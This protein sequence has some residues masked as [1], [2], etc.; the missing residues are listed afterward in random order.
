MGGRGGEVREREGEGKECE[1]GRERG[2]EGKRV[3]KGSREGG[4]DEDRVVGGGWG[5]GEDPPDRGREG[6]RR[7]A[8]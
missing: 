2:M 8:A 5:G 4:K 7:N 6:K 3:G 1:G